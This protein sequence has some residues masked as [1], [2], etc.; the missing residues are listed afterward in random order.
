M[1]KI[2]TTRAELLAHK[3][4]LILARQGRNL[5]EQQS[6][7]RASRALARAEAVA[8][9]E[10]VRS[11]ALAARGDLPLNLKMMN[12][13]G[14]KIPHIEHRT[15]ARSMMNRGYAL[16]GTS[17]SIDEAASA[18]EEEIEA[19]LQLAESEL[20]LT[21]LA[22]EIQRTSRR[23]NAL[24][25]HLIPRLEEEEKYIQNALDE[26]ERSDHFR[27]KLIKGLLQQKADPT[28]YDY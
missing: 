23:L 4:Q 25:N 27:M 16:S 28:E 2:S 15:A 1:R 11:A 21:R 19:I 17:V 26:R 10:A 9:V 3:E 24:E 13:M 12:V 22:R 5:L 8:G 14:I 20:R 7:T 18:F 6:A